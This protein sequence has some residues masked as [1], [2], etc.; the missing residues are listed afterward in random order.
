MKK[1]F[2]L[3]SIFILIPVCLYLALNK[4]NIDINEF[5]L[6]SG[7]EEVKLSD[8]ITS[9]KDIGG[10][11]NKVIVL[12]HGATF[13]SLAYEEYVDVFVENNYRVITYD[14]YGRGYSD[15]IHNDVSIE[16]MERQLKELIDYC[17]VGDII[18]YGVSFGAAVVAKYAAN[19]PEKISFVGYQV[20]LINSA[21][22]PM[23]SIANIP[24]Y[25]DLLI[26]GFLVPG[27]LKRIEGYEDLMS[28]KLLDHYIGQF[29]VKGTEKFF[30]KF[31]LGNAMGD[32][33]KDHSIIGDKSILSYF[34][35]AEDDIEIDSRLV[36][37]A[38][39]KYNNPIVK[40]YT[41]GHFFS[42]GI[43]R[44]LAQEFIDSIDEISN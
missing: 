20:P 28:K 23:L 1:V 15:R 14:Q 44:E 6:N 11:N 39:K 32:R 36:E 41:G 40:K 13:G 21:N 3:L 37:E 5:R 22:I 30:K 16:L 42:S 9:Y 24:L 19:N 17:G 33:L 7:Y 43:E 8:G 31:F 25:G 12:V 2:F 38:I 10:K 26:R 27:I 18:L 34:A 4:E 35:Y 29:S